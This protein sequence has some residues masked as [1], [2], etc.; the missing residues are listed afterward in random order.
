ME[1]DR[2]G[3]FG[4]S[5][6]IYP[7]WSPPHKIKKA[8]TVHCDGYIESLVC[9]VDR[10]Q[11]K[12]Y[13]CSASWPGRLICSGSGSPARTHHHLYI[14][15]K[16]TPT[17]TCSSIFPSF[18]SATYMASLNF[19]RIYVQPSTNIGVID[20]PNKSPQKFFLV[21]WSWGFFYQCAAT[22]GR[23]FLSF[24]PWTGNNR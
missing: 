18:K 19:G 24:V 5:F 10:S 12:T 8:I 13:M 7:H 6:S 22:G 23:S 11:T 4:W 1:T 16:N 21:E 3:L 2:G 9:L 20:H 15:I 14:P 17:V